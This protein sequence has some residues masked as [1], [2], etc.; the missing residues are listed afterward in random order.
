[1]RYMIN[2]GAA[3][4]GRDPRTMAELAALAE[5]SGWDALLL[6][7]YISYPSDQVVATYDPWVCLAAMAVATTRLRLGTLVTPIS[8]RRPWKLA[9]EAVT[10]DHLSGGRVI[11]SVGAGDGREPSFTATA[12]PTDPHVLAE[13]LDE[14]VA[15]LAALWRGEAVSFQGTHYQV[16]GLRLWPPPVQQPRIPL[17]VGGN[18]FVAGVRRRLVRW[19]GCCVYRGTPGTASHQP[20]TAD[21][22]HALVAWI[23]QERGTLEGFDVCIGGFERGPDT[24]RER[25]YVRSVAEVGAT[26]CQEWVPL[27]ELERTREAI[28][29][30]PLRID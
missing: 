15:L 12:E 9:S 23:A 18:W 22:V 29:R 13:R 6:E 2:I 26:W 4:P 14:G 11:L 1:M 20:M 27:G 17:W 7:D 16:D 21:D 30:G 10:L 3:G 5:N 24:E 28:S 25:A 8:R 19:D